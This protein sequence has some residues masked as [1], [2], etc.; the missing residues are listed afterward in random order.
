MQSSPFQ[1]CINTI[2]LVI[3]KVE[4]FHG[5]LT[6]LWQK[7]VSVNRENIWNFMIW[8]FW[9]LCMP[10]K[11]SWHGCFGFH[12]E[13]K[14]THLGKYYSY[15]PSVC[16]AKQGM[17]PITDF[18]HLIMVTNSHNECFLKPKCYLKRNIFSI[19]ILIACE[20]FFILFP[21]FEQMMLPT[22]RTENRVSSET[23]W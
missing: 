18:W 17:S 22:M 20:V 15:F 21:A 13:Q 9:L 12:R 23:L 6:Q 11:D 16:I 3:T 5:V 10:N 1:F 14:C 4:S 7:A 19:V 2:E 8:V